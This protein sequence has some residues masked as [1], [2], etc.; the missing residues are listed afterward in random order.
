MQRQA[1]VPC[2]TVWELQMECRAKLQVREEVGQI[3][4]SGILTPV[5][6]VT[7]QVEAQKVC[8]VH[9]RGINRHERLPGNRCSINRN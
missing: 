7:Q 8:V 9:M 4:V 1:V 2:G 5:S 6:S 3:I